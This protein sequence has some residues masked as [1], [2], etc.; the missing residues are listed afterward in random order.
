M[1]EPLKNMYSPAF[2]EALCP[3]LKE[4]LPGFREKTFIHR[5]F[6]TEWPQLEL[7]QRVRHITHALHRS[8]ET[9]YPQA[10][11]YIVAIANAIR[12][13]KDPQLQGFACIFLPDYLEVYG[14]E[15]YD[16]SMAAMEE[17]TKLISAEF[18]IRPF[19]LRYPEKTFKHML[20][21]SKHADAQV[22][23]L[24]SEG[25]RPRL[26]WGMGVPALKKDPSPILP[27]LENLK[28]DP[29]ETV[30]KSVANN[31]ND[32]AKDHP[33][34]VLDLAQRWQGKDPLTNW[35]IKHGCR[36]LLKRGHTEALGLH[37]FRAEHKA[38]VRD[39][40]LPPKV[41]VGEYLEWSFTFINKEASDADFRL[42]Y[43]IDYLTASGKTSRKVFKIT[44]KTFIPG[45]RC[46]FQRRQSFKDF[47]TRKHFKGIH[48]LSIVVNG[49]ARASAEF[50]V[51]NAR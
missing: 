2:F 23:R 22:R 19:L 12:K 5:V 3:V 10:A 29:A 7:K 21:W 27:I 32:I 35:I 28:A 40:V 26:P 37:G 49:K 47:T 6:D 46:S 31:L 15:H 13:R 16:E 9:D 44:E 24:S 11:K 33:E 14:L 4:N 1:A 8:I 25:G 17:V 30:R 41:R 20:R 39:L 18:A 45:E 36:T 34:L 38:Q 48:N 50:T 43:A 51:V 42:E